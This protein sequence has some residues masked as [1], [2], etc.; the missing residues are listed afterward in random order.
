MFSLCAIGSTRIGI[1]K[2]CYTNCNFFRPFLI[3]LYS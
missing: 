3:L 2:L 1:E